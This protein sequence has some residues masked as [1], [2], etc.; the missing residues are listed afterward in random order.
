MS[1]DSALSGLL[2]FQA[3]LLVNNEHA[4]M[5]IYDN[6]LRLFALTSFLWK[7]VSCFSIL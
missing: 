1:E 4:C 7:V 3:M 6:N 5:L 2:C